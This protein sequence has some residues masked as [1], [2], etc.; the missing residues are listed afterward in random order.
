MMFFLVDNILDYIGEL[1]MNI[2]KGAK[3]FLPFE[4]EGRKAFI[5]NKSI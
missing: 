2:G 5:I 4:I 3:S 1:G